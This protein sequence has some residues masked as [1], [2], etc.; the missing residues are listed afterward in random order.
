MMTMTVL[1]NTCV[2]LVNVPQCGLD[3]HTP[4]SSDSVPHPAWSQQS[5]LHCQPIR[6]QYH[7]CQP[8]R[9][10]YIICVNYIDMAVTTNQRQGLVCVFSQS[11]ISIMLCQPIRRLCT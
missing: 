7:M 4:V 5:L 6:D 1:I 9:D 2:H 10:Q 3:D 11:G 8:I